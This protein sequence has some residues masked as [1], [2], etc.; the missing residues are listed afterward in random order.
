M[1]VFEIVLISVNV[2]AV[3]LNSQYRFRSVRIWTAVINLAVFS[4]HGIF[5][6]FRYQMFFSYIFILLLSV[7]SFAN[8]IRKSESKTPK[9]W[10][11]AAA[12][13]SFIFLAATGL[14]ASA[15]PVFTLPKLTGDYAAGV[16]Y[17]HLVDETRM[18]PFLDRSP[19]KRELML[20]VYYPAK[21]DASQPLAPYFHSPQLLDSFAAFYGMP[22]FAFDHLNLVKTR[23]KENLP[24]AD[25]QQTYPVILFSHG[26]GTSMEVHT[27]QSE[28]LASHG[29]IVVSI[30][31]T[32]VS[33]A[34]VLPDRIISHHEATTNFNTPEPA[35]IITQIM[36]DDISFVIDTLTEMQAGKIR[37]IFQRRLDLEN[38]GVIGHSVGGAA[39]YNLA[40]NES[41]VKAAIN[42][43]G[44]VYILPKEDSP[45][46]TPFLMLTNEYHAQTIENQE[47]L[48]QRFEDMDEI[49]QKITLEIYGSQESYQE[50]Y[51]KAQQNVISLGQ[52]LKS[53]RNLFVIE[54]SDH[55][56]FTDIGF[57]FGF[58]QLRELFGIRGKTDPAKCLE[59]TQAL[60]R[61]FFDQHLKGESGDP[62]NALVQKYPELQRVP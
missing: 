9:A 18:D 56:K 28:D 34:T 40:I 10:K 57:Y 59:I 12:A 26:A 30:D 1:R 38:I 51:N 39:A 37:S 61:A 43:D 19:Q 2:L 31:H 21:T 46:T 54:G 6:G 44:K 13:L 48:L 23:S 22:D 3:I 29:Y 27:S 45:I 24:I 15:L 53:T 32:F 50:E 42:L 47:P 62:L 36:A 33:A 17:I 55:M 49:D 25:D 16:Q 58:A 14:T 20:K 11:A 7:F 8:T 5:E 35:E 52:T 60:T 4:L 41:R